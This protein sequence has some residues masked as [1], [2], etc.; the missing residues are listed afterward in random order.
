MLDMRRVLHAHVGPQAAREAHALRYRLAAH[1]LAR[2]GR[3]ARV[4]EPAR[5]APRRARRLGLVDVRRARQP[6]GHERRGGLGRLRRRGWHRARPSARPAACPARL[7][8]PARRARPLAPHPRGRG[9]ERRRARPAREERSHD[10]PGRDGERPAAD[11]R[12][13]VRVRHLRARAHD[14]DEPRGCVRRPSLLSPG[15]SAPRPSG[16]RRA[17]AD[18]RARSGHRN[19]HFGRKEHKC[20]VCDESFARE[21]DRKR[22]ERRS[23]ASAGVGAG[24]GAN[25]AADGTAEMAVDPPEPGEHATL[26]GNSVGPNGAMPATEAAQS[27][28]SPTEATAAS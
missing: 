15:A 11:A 23:H 14:E 24:A 17:C 21:W 19:A 12:G 27:Q 5:D 26:C 1:D 10:G 13:Q 16:L 8:R 4:P 9:P 28:D 6:D 3:A 7:A 22:H 18:A 20:S 25:P 2:P